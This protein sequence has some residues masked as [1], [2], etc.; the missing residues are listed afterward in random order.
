[1]NGAD[2]I[3]NRLPKALVVTKRVTTAE[4]IKTMKTKIITST[5]FSLFVRFFSNAE[6]TEMIIYM[7]A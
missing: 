4:Q 5:T 1:M 3:Y 2:E 7:T 6:L